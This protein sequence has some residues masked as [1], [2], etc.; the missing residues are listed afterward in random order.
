MGGGFRSGPVGRQYYALNIVNKLGNKFQ[1]I[2]VHVN[3]LFTHFVQLQREH[4]G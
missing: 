4:F 1:Y 3:L 2:F